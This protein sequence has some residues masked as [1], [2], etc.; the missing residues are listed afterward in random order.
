M[1]SPGRVAPAVLSTSA[2]QGIPCAGT[3]GFYAKDKPASL[4]K[5]PSLLAQ[6]GE[7]MGADV[8]GVSH[9]RLFWDTLLGGRPNRC[10]HPG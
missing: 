1:Q 10:L 4:K 9:P 7:S 2:G 8:G 3:A 6:W 5:I